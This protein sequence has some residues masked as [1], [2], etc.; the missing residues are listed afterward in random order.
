MSQASDD[1]LTNPD[2]WRAILPDEVFA[3]LVRWVETQA[4]RVTHRRWLTDGR[5][6]S[7]VAVVRLH[8]DRGM[9]REAIVKLVP[10][11]LAAAETAGVERARQFTPEN[12]WRQHLV[13]TVNAC[14]LPGT[15][16][17]LHQQQVAQGSVGELRSL[18][19]LL[20]EPDFGEICGMIVDRI[21]A[22]WGTGHDP[23]PVNR[24][25]AD[26]LNDFLEG[27]R[28]RL[29][30][31]AARHG[32]SL[33]DPSREVWLPGRAGPLP[34]PLG[35]LT[36]T[37]DAGREKID[38]F[39]GNG[40]GDLHLGNVLVPTGERVLADNFRLIDLGRFSPTTPV[41]R[42]PVKLALSVAAAWLP[43]LAPGTPL[44][45]A[46][47]ELVVAPERHPA[48]PPVAGYLAVMRRIH[49]AAASWG[50]S[51]DMSGAW[52]RQHLLLLIGSA[53]RTVADEDLPIA[54]RW[55]FFEVAALATRAYTDPSGARS[56][57][58]TTPPTQS[59]PS[60]AAS[61]AAVPP[62][63]S[64]ATEPPPSVTVTP[65]T[66]PAQVVVP[67]TAAPARPVRYPGRIKVQFARRL[68]QSW[69]DLVDV[70]DVPVYDRARFEPGRRAQALWEWLEVRD[71]LWSL[72]AALIE[73]G[74]DDLVVLLDDPGPPQER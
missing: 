6:G 48:S 4:S 19:A 3:G 32:L 69:D 18:A 49:T 51:R 61:P 39:V 34:N 45:S 25:A 7:Y 50:Q 66:P 56:Q 63:L 24:P 22:D 29:A 9:L 55:W 13:D 33:T 14:A 40:H 57:T 60:D 1:R 21:S 41:S 30:G 16:W 44:R 17:W 27:H 8:P 68:G 65:P 71:R 12:F 52:A 59:G 36:D 74:R 62:S 15:Y 5:S 73:V 54:D 46:L 26:H 31:F 35:L 2:A 38:V 43:A 28:D 58:P 42:D 47:A 67:D 37:L 11:Q 10:P 64:P 72:R 70:L 20:D 23:D 53:L